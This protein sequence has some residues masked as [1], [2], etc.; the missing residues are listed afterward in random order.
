MREKV[1]EMI[2]WVTY[3]HPNASHGDELFQD[4]VDVALVELTK[5][6]RALAPCDDSSPM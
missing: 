1:I 6:V 3:A 2:P 5:N 4:A